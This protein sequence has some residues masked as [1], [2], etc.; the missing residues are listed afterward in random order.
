MGEEKDMGEEAK[1]KCA[2]PLESESN[3][4][5]EGEERTAAA[6]DEEERSGECAWG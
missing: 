4:K 5:G 1:L 3:G 6:E 2:A